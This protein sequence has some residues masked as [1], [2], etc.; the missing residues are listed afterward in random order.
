MTQESSNAAVAQK[1]K[2]DKDAEDAGACMHEL[3]QQLDSLQQQSAS[4]LSELNAAH[5]ERATLAAALQVIFDCCSQRSLLLFAACC[6]HARISA[7]DA[8]AMDAGCA[9]RQ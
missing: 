4:Q 1:S 5:Q 6:E 7:D 3:Q 2:A 9:G 8:A